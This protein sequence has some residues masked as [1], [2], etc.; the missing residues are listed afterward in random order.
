M[1]LTTARYSTPYKTYRSTLAQASTSDYY[2]CPRNKPACREAVHERETLPMPNNTNITNEVILTNETNDVMQKVF[3]A[4]KKKL[5]TIEKHDKI[6]LH[7]LI[8]NVVA[9]THIQTTITQGLIAMFLQD[10]IRKGEGTMEAGRN[11]G[12]FKG[13]KKPHV[14]NR[15]KCGECG[16]VWHMKPLTQEQIA[17]NQ[18]NARK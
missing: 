4:A 13:G 5:D 15:P 2:Q 6:L 7:D 8:D 10:C 12:Y 11:G 18:E 1:G 9:E 16:R 3:S 14:D 17:I